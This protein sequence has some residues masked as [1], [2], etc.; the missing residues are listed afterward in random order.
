MSKSFST[1]VAIFASEPFALPS[2]ADCTASGQL[3]T[4]LFCG[5]AEAYLCRYLG[6]CPKFEEIL[7]GGKA[8]QQEHVF[9][10]AYCQNVIK[11]VFGAASGR[12]PD[13]VAALDAAVPTAP[14]SPTSNEEDTERPLAG[15][16][17]EGRCAPEARGPSLYVGDCTLKAWFAE[18]RLKGKQAGGATQ[19][20]INDRGTQRT[21]WK[22]GGHQQVCVMWP[23]LSL[24]NDRRPEGALIE[25]L[26]SFPE[27]LPV[28]W[29]LTPT[30]RGTNMAAMQQEYS[31]GKRYPGQKRWSQGRKVWECLEKQIGFKNYTPFM[32]GG[33]NGMWGPTIIDVLWSNE[34]WLTL[35]TGLTD[36]CHPSKTGLNKY[37]KLAWDAMGRH[38]L[39][40]IKI[41][42]GWHFQ[43]NTDCSFEGY[44]REMRMLLQTRYVGHAIDVLQMML[45]YPQKSVPLGTMYSP[46]ELMVVRQGGSI[47]PPGLNPATVAT[48]WR[49][50]EF[51]PTRTPPPFLNP[52]T[53]AEDVA[54]IQELQESTKQHTASGQGSG[55]MEAESGASRSGGGSCE[56]EENKAIFDAVVEGMLK[57]GAQWHKHKKVFQ[58]WHNTNAEAQGNTEMD[59]EQGLDLRKNTAKRKAPPP[60]NTVMDAKEGLEPKNNTLRQKLVF[61]C[62]DQKAP[63]KFV[64]EEYRKRVARRV[65]QICENPDLLQAENLKAW[66][67]GQED[68]CWPPRLHAPP[69][70]AQHGLRPVVGQSLGLGHGQDSPTVSGQ[71][72][73]PPS[74]ADA[75]PAP[76]APPPLPLAPPPSVADAS[77]AA[78]PPPAPPAAHA[79]P[80]PPTPS[81]P[82]PPPPP[83]P[84]PPCPEKAGGCVLHT[85][86]KRRLVLTPNPNFTNA[87]PRGRPCFEDDT[88]DAEA[89]KRELEPFDIVRVDK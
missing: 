17:I 68:S 82:E 76:D 23:R 72:V 64:S 32:C 6:V 15:F 8:V 5:M 33:L 21:Q 51:P 40:S 77:P 7:S 24:G 19:R 69:P 49:Q 11:R 30:V 46:R 67:H 60:G 28:M 54:R 62:G 42:D 41:I 2:P 36:P 58:Q 89:I 55:G 63:Y 20:I 65:D 35:E 26:S 75:S 34:D 45:R 10:S 61:S 16:D 53:I 71:V 12:T 86:G 70:S 87:P 84:P 31:D 59:A 29:M 52:A 18:R 78:P 79:P 9:C 57:G 14:P 48:R 50:R 25:A 22:E 37:R 47:R 4:Q 80:H 1:V 44:A 88:D 39:L 81:K 3:S 83:P 74:A 56:I 73:P 43:E 85:A 66:D 38:D 27:S 13:K